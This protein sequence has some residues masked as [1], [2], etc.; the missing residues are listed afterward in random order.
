MNKLLFIYNMTPLGE[1]GGSI[2]DT[3]K[4]L[5]IMVE[6]MIIYKTAI[7]SKDQMGLVGDSLNDTD[8]NQ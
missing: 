8:I 6:T 1:G 7:F 4:N 3:H 5:I 2:L